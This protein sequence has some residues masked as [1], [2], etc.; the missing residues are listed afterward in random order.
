MTSSWE[1]PGSRFP[2]RL[3]S[4]HIEAIRH[5]KVSFDNPETSTDDGLDFERCSALHN[6]I[7]KHAWQAQGY[8]LADLPSTT[9]WQRQ[10]YAHRLDEVQKYLPN[11][12]LEFLKRAIC[13]A[14]EELPDSSGS[15]FF[16]LSDC[17]A[18]PDMLWSDSHWYGL[19]P[20]EGVADSQTQDESSNSTR[21]MDR[22]ALYLTDTSISDET[23]DGIVC[24]RG[25]LLEEQ[26]ILIR[27]SYDYD[28][29]WSV[30]NSSPYFVFEEA[31]SSP[32][33]QRL[34]TI[35][36]TWIE[37]IERRK[38]AVVHKDLGNESERTLG[39][40]LDRQKPW[41]WASC[42]RSLEWKH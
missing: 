3:N 36:T 2:T 24:V 22:I 20:P 39:V 27:L 31:D 1:G 26:I 28:A 5:L 33:W 18:G 10:A 13:P 19:G 14:T 23:L 30:F 11:S 15:Y 34:E 12:L 4:E 8:D 37:M 7:V 29:H 6:A 32:L 21:D 38:V 42:S 25:D 35:L 40:Y 17:L 16:Y 9:L 41:G